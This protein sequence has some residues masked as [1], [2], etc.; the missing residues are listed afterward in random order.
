MLHQIVKKC[1]K[2]DATCARHPREMA[3]PQGTS[4]VLSLQVLYHGI[5]KSSPFQIDLHVSALQSIF[6]ADMDFF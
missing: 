3:R 1:P 4:I 2:S 6:E 5:Y